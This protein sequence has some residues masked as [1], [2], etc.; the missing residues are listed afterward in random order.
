MEHTADGDTPAF[1]VDGSLTAAVR[2]D[3]EGLTVGAGERRLPGTGT[4]AS[5]PGHAG[6]GH[7]GSRGG[8]GR[9]GEYMVLAHHLARDRIPSESRADEPRVILGL[10]PGN[11]VW[12]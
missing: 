1:W 12:V 7:P 10:A 3:D 9:R 8:T 6:A 11:R 2:K 5:P 4:T